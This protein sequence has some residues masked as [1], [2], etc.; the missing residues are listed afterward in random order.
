MMNNEVPARNLTFDPGF[1]M[2]EVRDGFT[3]SSA[4]KKCWASEME[5]LSDIDILCKRYDIPYFTDFGTTLGAVR[6]KGFIPWDDDIDIAMLRKDYIRFLKIAEK[7]LPGIY[8]V[9][10]VHSDDNQNFQL[11]ACVQNGTLIRFDEPFLEK[12]HGFPY[13]SSVDIFPL[14]TLPPES[15]SVIFHTM[16]NAAKTTYQMLGA[17]NDTPEQK[18]EMIRQVEQ[19]F[20][21]KLPR[22]GI[23]TRLLELIDETS[24][25]Y[26]EEDGDLTYMLYWLKNIDYRY[27]RAAYGSSIHMQFESISLPVPS[28]YDRILKKMYGNYM[29]K[30]RG[31]ADHEYPI[32]A[33]FER[34]IKEKLGYVPKL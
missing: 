2:E 13:I 23:K 27:D 20:N 5:I 34:Q 4:M 15:E 16:L 17:K 9:Y 26:C 19:I 11:C 21:V 14:D 28:G 25:M 12:Y 1:F 24:G 22:E 3:V 18:E 32:Y 8:R 30:T 29:V 10:H 31:K 6:H 7:E 33:K